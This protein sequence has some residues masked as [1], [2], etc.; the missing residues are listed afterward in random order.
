LVQDAAN[1]HRTKLADFNKVLTEI[2][3]NPTV[4]EDSE[5]EAKLKVL[6]EK[7][8]ILVEDA[9]AGTG[10]G[11]KSLTQKLDDLREHLLKIENTILESDKLQSGGKDGIVKADGNL[12]EAQRVIKEASKELD[13]SISLF[14]KKQF[15]N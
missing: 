15:K 9:K 8:N 12:E 3:E 13:V 6:H 2:A 4:I 14:H 11:E 7:I 10:G 5:F 1:E